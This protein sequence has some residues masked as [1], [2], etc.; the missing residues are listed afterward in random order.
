MLLNRRGYEF[1]GALGGG[2]A[3]EKARKLKPDVIL[4]DVMLPGISGW[5]IAKELKE[6]SDTKDITIVMLSALPGGENKWRSFN[7]AAAD[8][9]MPKP[10]ESELLFLVLEIVVQRQKGG[11]REGRIGEIISGDRKMRKV[12]EMINPEL[13]E[14]RYSFLK[15]YY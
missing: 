7:Y 2:D 11:E 15:A 3:I 1:Y 12:L 13:L 8:W 4:L 5:D 6:G 9:H 10:F 14:S